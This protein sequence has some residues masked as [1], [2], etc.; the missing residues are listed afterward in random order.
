MI[1]IGIKMDEK[2]ELNGTDKLWSD[3]AFMET[4][5]LQDTIEKMKTF[6]MKH[7]ED[8]NYDCIKCSKKISA[9]NRD[10]HNYMCDDCFKQEYFKH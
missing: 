3:G 9:H 2:E 7:N 5:D 6:H 4:L 1:K 8:V 10:W